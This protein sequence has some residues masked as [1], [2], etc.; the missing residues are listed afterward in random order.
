MNTDAIEARRSPLQLLLDLFS[1]VWFGVGLL[2]SIFVYSSIGSALPPVRQSRFLEMT[3]FEWFHW[4]PFDL[5][6]GLLVANLVIVTVR[7]I[8]F[9]VTN[10][11]V[12]MIHTGIVIL[13]VGSVYY[14]G[15]KL[16]G[17]V[18]VFRR[19]VV[20]EVP[21]VKTPLTMPVLPGN[22]VRG[23]GLGGRYEFSIAQVH[24]KWPLRTE[25]HVGEEA[26]SVSVNV[27]TPTDN[28]VRQ[29]L[30]GYPQYTEDII[31]GKGRAVKAVG[32]KL[33]DESLRIRL[34]YQPQDNFYLM[35]TA[36]VYVRP[37]G[38][39]AWS[40]RQLEGLPHYHE[41]I[42]DHADVWGSRELGL[43]LE[44]LRLP[45][46]PVEADDG[47][48]D[49]DVVVT[50]YLRYATMRARWKDG[51]ARLN[52]VLG[53][54]LDVAGQTPHDLDLA[55]F[56][57]AAHRSGGIDFAWVESA[58]ELAERTHAGVARLH[59]EVPEH[60]VVLDV[61]VP[62]EAMAAGVFEAI[63]S[64]PFAYRI[65][66]RVD[67]LP[68]RDGRVVSVVLVE[69]R[70]PERTFT[71]MVADDPSS[72]HDM[73]PAADSS[74]HTNTTTDERIAM[75]YHSAPGRSSLT[76]FAG[77]EPIGFKVAWGSRLLSAQLGE[78]L[79]LN[80]EVALT[81][82]YL[83]K[84]ARRERR[85]WIIP[86]AERDREVRKSLS[87]VQVELS[88]G[89]WR[90]TEWLPYHH[91]V[92][93]SAQYRSGFL[94]FAP[95]TVKMPNGRAIELLFSRRREPLPSA[96]ALHDF[97]LLTHQGGLIGRNSN[98]RD[99]VSQL[100]FADNT[101]GWSEP[102]QMSLN[103]PAERGG[104]WFFQSFWD[105]PDQNSAGMNYTGV[106]VGNR[107][108]VYIQLLGT[109]IAVLGMIYAFYI[110]PI[111]LRRHRDRVYSE[112]GAREETVPAVA[113][114]REHAVVARE[115]GSTQAPI[116]E[117]SLANEERL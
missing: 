8:P 51:G 24:P 82:K 70:T 47:L 110:K 19:Q 73:G 86:L 114:R 7:R 103:K 12:W 90:H 17:D 112:L 45:G 95:T 13:C 64:S 15:T 22:R 43:P 77:P 29:V 37:A 9:R 42:G 72:T 107:N 83:Y 99:Y 74:G 61:D 106:G 80:D 67:S 62:D 102:L 101:G 65:G 100:C 115:N 49:V 88:S 11:G 52:P 66:N 104:F 81:L 6:I 50:G 76:V 33:L 31:P 111:I 87:M 60:E 113:E 4:W 10:L 116:V 96:V 38:S 57:A 21:G 20:I 40:Q 55:A 41:R 35:D 14:F 63:G 39:E 25:P 92:F 109:V 53:V 2:V 68:L 84:N 79:A 16:E 71:R 91:Y 56:D 32:R 89:D 85:P 59:I 93:P 54:M 105:A 44:R 117:A 28:F 36:A 98:V 48:P 27:T 23:E 69:I 97:T 30:A 46:E 3:E 18:P 34:E 1:S 78:R 5:L 75:T 58:E 108:G 94:R 26:Y